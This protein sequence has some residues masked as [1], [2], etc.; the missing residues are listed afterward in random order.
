MATSE[1]GLLPMPSVFLAHSSHDR[2]LVE[3]IARGLCDAGITVWFAPWQMV[4]GHSISQEI[5]KGLANADL[6]VVCLS[7]DAIASG[8]V[9]KEWQSR[10]ASEAKRR[11]VEVIPVRLHD[12]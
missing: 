4:A 5:S 7:A 6:V 11:G 10:M 9:E 12:C 3:G 1:T 2:E 8:W